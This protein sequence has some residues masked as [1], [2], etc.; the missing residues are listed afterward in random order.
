MGSRS[1]AVFSWFGTS[2]AING[3]INKCVSGDSIRLMNKWIRQGM[4]LGLMAGL[5][6]SASAVWALPG[7]TPYAVES[8]M[9]SNPTLGPADGRGLTVSQ[10]ATPSR[11]FTFRATIFPVGGPLQLPGEAVIRTEELTLFDQIDEVD[12]DRLEES[13][14]VIYGPEIYTDY[15]QAELLYA[16]PLADAPPSPNPNLVLVGEVLEGDR[17]AYWLELA[18]NPEGVV[19]SGRATVFLKEDLPLL[20]RYLV[21]DG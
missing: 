15:R 8:W 5:V 13:L 9:R 21:G 14:R 10:S 11:R 19:Y 3:T 2:A 4:G 18:A 12:R 20:R 16:Y 1:C 17:Y 7:E 6:A